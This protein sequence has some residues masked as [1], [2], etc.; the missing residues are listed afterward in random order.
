MEDF[1]SDHLQHVINN[2]Q[3]GIFIADNRGI[4]LWMNDTSTKQLGAPRSKLIG[5]HVDKLEKDGFFNPSVTK[6]VIKKRKTVSKVQ[7]SLNRK[8]LATGKIVTI[9][10]EQKEYILVQVKD[11]T[12]TVR[13]SLKLEQAEFLL[14]KY[15]DELRRIKQSHFKSLKQ[16]IIG[17]SKKHKQMMNMIDQVAQYDATILL[18]GETGVGKS[19]IAEEIHLKSNRS[20]KPF[21]QINCSAIPETL[22]ES[23]LFGYKRGAFT[24]A[25]HSGKIGLVESADGGTLFLDEIAELPIALQSK[26]LQLV[27][28]KSFIPIG[29]SELKKVDVRIITATNGDLLQLI[30]EKKFRRDLYYRLNVIAI[31][32]PALRE[33]KEDIIQ[34]IYHYFNVFT[35]KYG[36]NLTLA[37]E[38]LEALQHYQWP[39]NIRELENMIERLVV[40]AT[41]YIIDSTALPEHVSNREKDNHSLSY[42][43]Q[44]QT[45]QDYLAEVEKCIIQKAQMEYES[46]RKAAQYLGLTQ[47]SYMRRLKKYHL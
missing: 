19:M 33:R 46:T 44:G 7:E 20:D 5:K 40:T 30:E 41:S 35:L 34:L 38:L 21:V 47:S 18:Q 8:Y 10:G 3:D 45:L 16:P 11:I 22:L 9:P 26:I 32:I 37:D 29:S 39:G 17:T 12:E 36:R 6:D 42:T 25:N 4:A 14:K 13:A 1:K 28:D 23:E 31:K 27:Q 15:W 24:G 2:L 43:L